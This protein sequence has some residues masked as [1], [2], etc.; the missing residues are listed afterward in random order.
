MPLVS[1]L[2]QSLQLLLQFQA[3]RATYKIELNKTSNEEKDS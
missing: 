1:L 3:E 2:A